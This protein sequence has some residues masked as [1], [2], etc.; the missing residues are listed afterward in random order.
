MTEQSGRR[1]VRGR[2]VFPPSAP[3][4]RSL[5]TSATARRHCHRIVTILT[6]ACNIIRAAFRE[7][8]LKRAGLASQSRKLGRGN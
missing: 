7:L 5:V 1:I 3:C 6:A 8:M 4:R 2:A